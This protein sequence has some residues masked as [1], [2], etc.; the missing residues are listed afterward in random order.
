MNPE[1]KISE[2]QP[3][4]FIKIWDGTYRY[5]Y[6]RQQLD[7]NKWQCLEVAL[8][9]KPNYANCVQAVIRKYISLDNEFDLINSYNRYKLGL[10]NDSST[11]TEYE[12]YLKLVDQIKVNVKADFNE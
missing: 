6:K 8:Q 9:D 3:H 5:N 12:E 7:T 10:S 2:Y 4:K 11:I 1:L